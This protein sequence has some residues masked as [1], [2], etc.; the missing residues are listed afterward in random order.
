MTSGMRKPPPI[1]ISSPRRYR[2]LAAQ[3]QAVE[4]QQHRRRVVVDHRCR[5]GAGELA[6]RVLDMVVPVAAGAC[7]PGRTRGWSQRSP[8]RSSPP[9]LRRAAGARPR[10]VCSTVPVRVEHRPQARPAGRVASSAPA[11]STRP[12]AL[13]ASAA[14]AARARPRLV[15]GAPQR[16]GWPRWRPNPVDE[17]LSVAVP[18]TSGRSRDSARRG[19]GGTAGRGPRLRRRVGAHRGRVETVAP[20][21][22][23]VVD[24]APCVDP[25]TPAATA[26]PPGSVSWRR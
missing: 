10:L 21:P 1:S 19:T 7:R 11:R 15:D 14:S 16:R 12:S 23:Q 17:R 22:P 5:G 2:H 24:P 4:H 13:T 8:L 18:H 3:R 6:H 20:A 9:P 26:S 25:A